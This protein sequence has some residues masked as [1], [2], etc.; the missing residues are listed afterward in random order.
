MIFKGYSFENTKGGILNISNSTFAGTWFKQKTGSTI[1]ILA[2]TKADFYTMWM[3][4]ANTNFINKGTARFYSASLG[5][6]FNNLGNFTNSAGAQAFFLG[7][8]NNTYTATFTNYGEVSFAK[9]FSNYGTF[10]NQ[11]GALAIFNESANFY[12]GTASKLADLTNSGNMIFNGTASMAGFINASKAILINNGRVKLTK[13]FTNQSGASV[14]INGGTLTAT[15]FNNGGILS[16]S[17]SNSTMGQLVVTDFV[18]ETGGVV[19]VDTSGMFANR[20]Y[21]IIIGTIIGLDSVE[22]IGEKGFYENGWVWLEAN[23]TN[24]NI[25]E[26]AL[27][28]YGLQGETLN[29]AIA[30]TEKTIKI[31]Y[32]TTPKAMISAFK[33]DAPEMPL[34]SAYV[35]RLTA[36]SDL[37]MSDASNFTNPLEK[38]SQ[39]QFFA[40]PFGG[41]LSSDD[42]S[43][44]LLGLTLGLTHISESYIAQGHFSYAR[45]QSKQDLATQSTDTTGDLFQVGGFTRLFASKAEFDIN[46]NFVLGKFAIDNVWLASE[47]SSSSNFNNYQANLGLV[48]GWRFGEALSF[49]PFVGVQGYYEKQDDFTQ[50]GGLGLASEAYN[51]TTM[52]ALAGLEG[53]YIFE[54]GGFGFVKFSYESKIHNSHK[55]FFMRV[56]N[57]QLEYENESYG[58]VMSANVG[59]RVF[60]GEGLEAR[61]RGHLQT[62]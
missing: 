44:H 29:K 46:A 10:K 49:K 19:S 33:I 40:M 25:L 16:F 2:G 20:K 52:D 26:N 32:I 22:F 56:D 28:D 47:M 53:R 4:E 38:T 57:E 58:S 23:K 12:E 30:D 43:G 15:T 24:D 39:T 59:F 6:N 5:L 54:N 7:Y 51:A 3:N 9:D 48:A 45:G 18:N 34:N 1:N 60:S 50:E 41:V 31:S 11:A 36:S 14:V 55:E 21:Q 37:I 17:M 13:A 35:S 8:T 42:L 61:H 62:L 27:M